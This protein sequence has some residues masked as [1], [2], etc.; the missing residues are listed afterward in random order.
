[1]PNAP[2]RETSPSRPD[3]GAA[4]VAIL[5]VTM[6]VVGMTVIVVQSSLTR[7][8]VL[9]D[10]YAEQQVREIVESA[11]SQALTR[12]KRGGMTA[13]V[14]GNG[15]SPVWV[16]FGEGLFYYTS[17]YDVLTD[18]TN[19]RVWARR[20]VSDKPSSSTVSPDDSGWDGT[21]WLVHGIEISVVGEKNFPR[22]PAY[23]G[24]GGIEKPL[25]GFDWGSG[26]DPA[27]PT[28]WKK[29]TGASSSQASWV[30][31]TIDA[32]DYPYDYLVN[33]GSPAGAGKSLLGGILKSIG[34]SAM[35]PFPVW[36]SQT[37]IGQFNADAWFNNSAGVGNDPLANVLPSP[38]ST[39]YTMGLPSADTHPYAVDPNLADVQAFAWALWSKYSKDPDANV[40]SEGSHSGD[41]GSISDPQITFVTGTLE[42]PDLTKLSGSGILVIRD[43]YDPNYDSN[44]TPSTKASLTVR[45]ELEWTGLIIVAGWAPTVQV[46]STGSMKLVG[47]LF[48][49]DSVQSGGEV[50][51]DSATIVL[52]ID[53]P[54]EIFYSDELFEPGGL[55]DP[56]IPATTKRIVGMREITSK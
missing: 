48:G 10:Q 30:P 47:S 13:P 29:A 40:L 54:M 46:T 44:N 33:G 49:E 42:I 51:L 45:G 7:S 15:T 14:S 38:T 56:F 4:L 35:H 31:M 26:V 1:M 17:T 6:V 8:R 50:S 37:P 19:I 43:D 55:I 18:T 2:T 39:V 9:A 53:G 34:G 36:A 5:M 22:A 32:R 24:N 52:D 12:V 23:F 16:D 20:A 25:G 21:G 27:D 3:R 28:T 11:A 41:F